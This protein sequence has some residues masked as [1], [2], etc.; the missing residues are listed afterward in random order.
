MTALHH[1]EA[2]D[3]GILDDA[4]SLC[5]PEEA[6]CALLGLD[7]SCSLRVFGCQ[8]GVQTSYLDEISPRPYN[9]QL[10]NI[11]SNCSD[12]EQLTW[13]KI[14]RVLIRPAL[15]EFKVASQLQPQIYKDLSGSSETDSASSL[16]SP[17]SPTLL[18]IGL[19]HYLNKGIHSTELND[20][21]C[22]FSAL[23][24]HLSILYAPPP[25]TTTT[26]THTP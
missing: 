21:E 13:T 17:R 26:T 6:W 22:K 25:P 4:A 7:L 24:Q 16:Q 12:H 15:E 5:T 20:S 14:V 19:E 11:L 23:T 10:L 1:Q 18:D 8:L 3:V 2:M 9:E